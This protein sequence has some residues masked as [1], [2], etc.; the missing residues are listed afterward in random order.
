LPLGL[1]ASLLL[2]D[3][4]DEWFTFLPAGAIESI[5]ADLGLSYGQAGMLR[6]LLPAGGFLGVV[7]MAAADFVSRRLLGAGGAFVFALCLLAFATGQSFAALAVASFLWG[8]ASD[9]LVHATQLAL[10]DQRRGRS[11]A[12]LSATC[13]CSGWRCSGG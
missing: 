13:A 1:L 8:A 9:A 3:L 6:A 12:P 4:A 5:R 11:R 2:V 10:A 7:L